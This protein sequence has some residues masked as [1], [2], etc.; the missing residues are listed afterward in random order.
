MSDHDIGDAPPPDPAPRVPPHS[1]STEAAV[2]SAWLLHD[3][4]GK[5]WKPEPE[6]FFVPAHR[7]IAA[8][9]AGM[10]AD[11][12]DQATLLARLDADGAMAKAGGPG[13]VLRVVLGAPAYGD[14]WPHV[15][16]LR[17][18]RA[19]REILGVLTV[20]SAEAYEHKSLGATV[21]KIQ[22]AIRV[23]TSD[24]GTTV[25]SVA[26]LVRAV[27]KRMIE[28]AEARFCSFGLPSVDRDT[29]GLQYKQVSIL[30][31]ASTWGKSSFCVMA[32]DIQLGK[33]KKP[34]IV[35][36]EDSEEIYGRRLVARRA[37]VKASM[38][39]SNHFREG[40]DDWNRILGVAESA[41]RDPFFINAIGKSAERV[42][43]DIR[44]VCAS[45]GIDL[46]LVDYIQAAQ[47]AR[48]QQDRRNEVTYISRIITDAIK[49]SGAAGLLFSQFKR[50]LKNGEKPSM[51]DL[52]ESGDLENMAEM[53]LLGY[54]DNEGKPV[55]KVDKC[56]DGVRGG[57]YR[58]SW[59]DVWCGF[60]GEAVPEAGDWN[61]Q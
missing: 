23:G 35:S 37:N 17:E 11:C 13:G 38:L 6:L 14:P 28:K 46:V 15:S 20:A 1:E 5:A 39:R 12:R 50:Q 44:C 61:Y 53:V 49:S 9:M 25:L 3:R 2:L 60:E 41:E 36:F 43:T 34:L 10:D 21:A 30:G 29:G 57:E 59:N 27:A 22:E 58:L 24:S 8:T 18:L 16:R 19:L 40:G 47:C 55:L 31:A 32:A 7:A 54:L 45:E 4:F 52:K 48:R 26:D 33:A 51:H 56:K 42:A